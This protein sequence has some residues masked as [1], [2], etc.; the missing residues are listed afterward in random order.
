M[1]PGFVLKVE[2]KN[3]LKFLEEQVLTWDD[4]DGALDVW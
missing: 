4:L 1:N 2:K 3:Q